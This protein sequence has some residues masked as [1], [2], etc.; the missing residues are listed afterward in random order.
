M[1]KALKT[2]SRPVVLWLALLCGMAAT[3]GASAVAIA[4]SGPSPFLGCAA[5]C[6]TTVDCDLGCTCKQDNMGGGSCIR[7]QQ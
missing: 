5:V 2:V 7:S 1:R 3:A 4:A 6:Q